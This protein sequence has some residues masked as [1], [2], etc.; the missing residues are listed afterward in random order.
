MD[1][2]AHAED[3]QE[4]ASEFLIF[5]DYLPPEGATDLSA[6]ATELFG[7]KTALLD[8][9][10][11][12]RNPR[13]ARTAE[14]LDDEQYVVVKS[15]EYTFKDVHRLLGGLV[16]GRYRSRREAYRAVW[17]KLEDFFYEES[18]NHLVDR[19]HYYKQ[20]LLE[21]VNLVVG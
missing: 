9:D 18:R 19:L 20:F 3:A 13:N 2:R 14:T 11:E 21:L 16:Q 10:S 8:L 5:Q 1:L 15:I 4:I 12:C 6:L 17:R 7:I